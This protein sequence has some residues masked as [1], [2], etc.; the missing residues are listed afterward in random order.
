MI[1]SLAIVGMVVGIGVAVFTAGFCRAGSREMP[2]P[3]RVTI[4]DGWCEIT[5]C[6]EPAVTVYDA[7]T[8]DGLLYVCETHNAR[9]S[10]WVARGAA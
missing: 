9:V 5:N 2:A 6:D 10:R 4:H 7:N 3:Q 8:T 1:Q